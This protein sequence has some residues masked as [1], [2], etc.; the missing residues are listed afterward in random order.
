[1]RQL[2]MFRDIANL[3]GAIIKFNKE[4]LQSIFNVKNAPTKCMTFGMKFSAPRD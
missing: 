3:N 2:A 4:S 1:M